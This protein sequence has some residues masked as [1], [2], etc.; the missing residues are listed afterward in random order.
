MVCREVEGQTPG[1]KVVVPLDPDFSVPRPVSAILC[2]VPPSV[3]VLPSVSRPSSDGVL[4]HPALSS[5]R[6]LSLSGS[7]ERERILSYSGEERGSP[8]NFEMILTTF[9][10]RVTLA[11]PGPLLIALFCVG[12]WVL[13]RPPSQAVPPG[14]TCV[15][16]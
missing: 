16:A 9:P 15:A 4:S 11:D 2:V 14:S 1:P 3:E 13:L 5:P 6:I 10:L 8:R 7:V 12:V